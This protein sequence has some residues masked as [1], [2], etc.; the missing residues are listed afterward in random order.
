MTAARRRG[1]TVFVVAVLANCGYGFAQTETLNPNPLLPSGVGS[2]SDVDRSRGGP[3]SPIGR[4]VGPGGNILDE[5]PADTL[6][7]EINGSNNS[8]RTGRFMFGDPRRRTLGYRGASP[9]FKDGAVLFERRGAYEEAIYGSRP[10]SYS[11]ARK[12]S[13]RTR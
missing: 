12:T 4:G 3:G 11:E 1:L 2:G 10:G 9:K 5:N 8:R 7:R 13:R 6:L